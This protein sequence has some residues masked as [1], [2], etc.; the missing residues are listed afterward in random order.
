MNAL[1]SE[2]LG[3]RPRVAT[4]IRR[5]RGLTVA[6]A[7]PSMGRQGT[8]RSG[9]TAEAS[10]SASARGAMNTSMYDAA[11][12]GGVNTAFLLGVAADLCENKE[13]F[14]GDSWR[15]SA[16]PRR[17]YER[18]GVADGQLARDPDLAEDPA[19]ARRPQRGVEPDPSVIVE[20][21]ARARLAE[22]VDPDLAEPEGRADRG[23]EVDARDQH[24]GAAHGWLDVLAEFAAGVVPSL[25]RQDRDLAL[26][27]AGVIAVEPLADDR[28]GALDRAHRQAR[29]GSQ[30]DRFD[31][32]HAASVTSLR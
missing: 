16:W 13:A 23:L 5:P 10:A 3:L 6:A 4:N 15:R 19:P 25:S 9:S 26:A 32:A 22:H 24:V 14:A 31:G 30:E 20:Q 8:K 29:C 2:A 11:G 18:R 27:A 28:G 21:L 7:A 17:P 12:G 1:S